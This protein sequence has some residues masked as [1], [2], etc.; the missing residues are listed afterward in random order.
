MLT[1]I[2]LKS[3]L[4]VLSAQTAQAT[5]GWHSPVFNLYFNPYFKFSI[6]IGTK[7][8]HVTQRNV[9]SLH[10]ENRAEVA[11]HPYPHCAPCVLCLSRMQPC[12]PQKRMFKASLF[13]EECCMQFCYEAET[14]IRTCSFQIISAMKYFSSS[15]ID[16]ACKQRGFSGFSPIKS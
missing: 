11:K 13:P 16:Q 14:L 4:L 15:S 2:P 3:K 8:S 6:H 5:C 9:R 12:I 1:Q 10:T 7:R